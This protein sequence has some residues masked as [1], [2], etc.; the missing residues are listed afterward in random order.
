MTDYRL[1]QMIRD[2][3]RGAMNASWKP[4][5]NRPARTPMS[6]DARRAIKAEIVAALAERGG[7]FTEAGQTYAVGPGG[8]IRKTLAADATEPATLFG[9]MA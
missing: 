7:A 2:R 4:C 9:A 3:E 1:I 6:A 8:S 5:R